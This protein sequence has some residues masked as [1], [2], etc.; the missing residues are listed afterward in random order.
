M[1]AAFDVRAAL[2][3]I[4]GLVPAEDGVIVAMLRATNRRLRQE[5]SNR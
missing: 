3:Q 5:R 1:R 4:A 2:Q